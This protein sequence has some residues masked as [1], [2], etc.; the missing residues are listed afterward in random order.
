MIAPHGLLHSHINLR[1][2]TFVTFG[3]LWIVAHNL[4]GPLEIYTL[5]SIPDHYYNHTLRISNLPIQSQKS[6]FYRYI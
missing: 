3:P 5:N 6:P 1:G 2:A 4:L